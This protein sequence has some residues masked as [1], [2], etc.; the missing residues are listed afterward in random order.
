MFKKEVAE[1]K[2][3][4]L[5]CSDRLLP[6]IVDA[7]GLLRDT[8]SSGTD[9]FNTQLDEKYYRIKRNR[10]IP[11]DEITLFHNREDNHVTDWH[12]DGPARSG[13]LLLLRGQ[14]TW[15]FRSH[16]RRRLFP[17]DGGTR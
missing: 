14:K 12:F 1:N 10:E 13:W 16:E 3:V 5:R 7:D 8:G 11:F 17:A 6:I 2:P 9:C 15:E 4:V